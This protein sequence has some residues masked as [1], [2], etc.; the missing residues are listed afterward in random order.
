MM[1]NPNATALSVVFHSS[2]ATEFSSIVAAEQGIGRLVT[3]GDEGLPSGS[4]EV[5]VEVYQRLLAWLARVDYDAW[6][7]NSTAGPKVA[8]FYSSSKLLNL[9]TTVDVVSP[10]ILNNDTLL[11]RLLND[12]DV[13]IP[14]PGSFSVVQLHQLA[15]A[16]IEHGVG[17]MLG[18]TVC[19]L[20][21]CP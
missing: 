19:L 4:A 5:G 21:T 1:F 20:T 17:I 3:A 15:N 10:T 2:M 11:Q 12:Y 9:N 6:Q 16:S 13:I 14:T 18:Y 7:A 8:T